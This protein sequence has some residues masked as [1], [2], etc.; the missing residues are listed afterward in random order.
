MTA[1]FKILLTCSL[2]LI[3]WPL[4][5]SISRNSNYNNDDDDH[6]DNNNDDKNNKNNSHDRNNEN[7]DINDSEKYMNSDHS[8]C[9][10]ENLK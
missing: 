1:W 7:N 6:N 8:I 2:A 10:I 4:G 5:L 9:S 3:G